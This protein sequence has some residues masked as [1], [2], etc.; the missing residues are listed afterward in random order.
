MPGH[1]SEKGFP[2]VICKFFAFF[3]ERVDKCLPFCKIVGD[4]NR[5]NQKKGM[6]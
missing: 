3:A 1:R 6:I 5:E 4:S 2:G